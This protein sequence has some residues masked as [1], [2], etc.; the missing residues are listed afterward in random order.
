MNVALTRSKFALY[1]VCHKN[2]LEVR[3]LAFRSAH[4]A[5]VC[6]TQYVGVQV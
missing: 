1:I 3:T 5:R 4:I 2:S 6:P